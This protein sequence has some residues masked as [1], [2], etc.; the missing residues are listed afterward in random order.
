L[1]I[2]EHNGR[3]IGESIAIM[4]YLAKIYE[5]WPTKPDT[6]AAAI[7]ILTATDDLRRVADAVRYAPDDETKKLNSKK[8]LGYMADR[9]PN[10]E[11]L[12]EQDGFFTS[13]R[14]TAADISFWDC[15][16]QI[17]DQNASFAEVISNFK[18]I[19]SFRKRIK[20]L[21]RIQR[22]LQTRK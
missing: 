6:E 10:F 13:G 18:Q 14:I 16:N 2:L 9:L 21:P 5:R 11:K 12:L 20:T 3:V 7:M 22:Y 15:L 4:V 17:S 8:L 19:D 1:P